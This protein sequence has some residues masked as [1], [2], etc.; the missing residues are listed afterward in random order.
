VR[1]AAERAHAAVSA[2][3]SNPDDVYRING[4]PLTW[5]DL[6]ALADTA[7]AALDHECPPSGPV[8]T[9][10]LRDQIAAVLY[11][12]R[13]LPRDVDAL[14]DE[15][16]DFYAELVSR[17]VVAPLL[18][19]A[20]EREER[21]R[22]DLGIRYGALADALGLPHDADQVSGYYAA[23]DDVAQ[24]RAEVK[25]LRADRRALQQAAEQVAQ[26][27]AR[28]SAARSRE[29][30]LDIESTA[31]AAAGAVCTAL[32]RGGWLSAPVSG[33]EPATPDGPTPEE[34]IRV[35]RDV[36]LDFCENTGNT[37]LD[38]RYFEEQARQQLRALVAAGWEPA[39][40]QAP[41][42]TP[43]PP[44]GRRPDDAFER[45]TQA[46]RSN[47]DR[48]TAIEAWLDQPDDDYGDDV[49]PQWSPADR[50]VTVPHSVL[51][52]IRHAASMA[53]KAIPDGPYNHGCGSYDGTTT[54]ARLQQALT[55]LLPYTQPADRRR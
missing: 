7:R 44:D 53:T 6:A 35:L 48:T 42:E 39:V 23:V 8:D 25:R 3:D 55:A 24:L 2:N 46:V 11:R 29:S 15:A 38:E 16:A 19:A 28:R 4:L 40:S 12:H 10:A 30:G 22:A 36:G 31:M 27:A 14:D 34:V 13:P 26:D 45:A 50:P 54:R 52:A 49:I 33:P 18:A 5:M 17:V 51:D 37:V 1:E 47:P 9:T 43:A 32:R 41:A 21:L 20:A